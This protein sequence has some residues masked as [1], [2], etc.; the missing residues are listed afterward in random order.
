MKPGV[1]S[2]V[3]RLGAVMIHRPDAALRRLTPANHDDFLF[4]DVMWVDRATA[5]HDAFTKILKDNGVEVLSQNRL[6]EETLASDEAR[7]YILENI[8]PRDAPGISIAGRL[9]E[10]LLDEEPEVLAGYLTGGLP[11]DGIEISGMS[12]IRSRSLLAAAAGPDSF[13]LPPLPNSIYTH[14]PSSWI[15][16][17]VSL[18]RM[19]WNVRRREVLN[20]SA[21]YRY[22]PVFSKSSFECWL[23][24]GN[25][26][27]VPPPGYG[28]N[29]LEGGDIMPLGRR[30]VLVGISE[31]TGPGMIEN[32]ASVLFAENEA[33]KIIV[34]EIG[35]DRAHMHLDTVFT[36][37]SEDSAT[38]YPGVIEKSRTWSLTPGEDGDVFSVSEEKGLVPAIE[39]A[40]DIDRLNVIA[41]GG[42]RYEAEREQW[43]DGNNVLAIRPGVV[44]A[45]MRNAYTN[46]AMEKEGIDVIEIEGF[47]LSRGRG[48]PHCMTCPIQRDG[49]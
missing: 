16:G 14:D 28:R 30:C 31:R 22:H 15:F 26:A 45:Y 37:I 41:T 40:L 11:V 3:G 25:F 35:R 34:C 19:Y 47:E 6:L 12:D 48:G 20:V 21:I 1:Y 13:V 8:F 39:D 43:D 27:G 9:K 38:A 4:D 23:P 49:I 17:G 10:A 24:K 42:D 5:E 7:N 2:E 29:T 46:R 44:V 18:N 36:M 32:L 33:D